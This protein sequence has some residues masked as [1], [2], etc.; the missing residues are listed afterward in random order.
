MVARRRVDDLDPAR[1]P[2]PGQ[3]RGDAYVILYRLPRE[4]V[5]R[6]GFVPVELEASFLGGTGAL[7]LVDS[8][9][10][11]VGPYQE[12]LFIP[13]RFRHGDRRYYSVTRALVS[14]ESSQA[15][16]RRRWGRPLELATFSRER[17]GNQERVC[18]AT[19]GRVVADLTFAAGRL[20]L[21][22]TTDVV[23]PANRSLLQPLDGRFFLSTPGGT[24][25]LRRARCIAACFDGTCL[26]DLTRFEPRMALHVKSF[27][28]VFPEAVVV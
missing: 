6:G 3:L 12:L 16:E 13:G 28:V 19:G 10:S 11:E 2:G 8:A 9:C 26:P 20:G 25:T 17:R 4:F 22:V 5:L 27:D 24:A 21:P 14:T 7:I 15:N 23:P 18:V 1:R